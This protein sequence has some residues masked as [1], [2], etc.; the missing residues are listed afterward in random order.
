MKVITTIALTAA[1]FAGIATLANA[2]DDI[3][4][5][6]TQDVDTG[7]EQLAAVKAATSAT[8][9]ELEGCTGNLDPVFAEALN[10]NEA[11]AQVLQQETVGAG[12]II[13][14]GI[15]GTTLTIYVSANDEDQD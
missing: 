10:A 8:V 9:V 13:G 3:C 4:S 1:L 5:Q 11:A 12:E 7:A 15:Q 14:L 6:I 2:Q